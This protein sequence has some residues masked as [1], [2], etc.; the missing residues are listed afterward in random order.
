MYMIMSFYN[1][2]FQKTID[3]K[4]DELFCKNSVFTM[5]QIC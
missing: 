3:V 1:L 4:I 2:F 5:E